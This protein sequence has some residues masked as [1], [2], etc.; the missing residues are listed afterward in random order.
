MQTHKQ[1]SD[2]SHFL[3]VKIKLIKLENVAIANTLQ[4]EATQATPALSHFNYNNPM[5]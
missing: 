4:L 2:Q 5:A 3:A 1:V